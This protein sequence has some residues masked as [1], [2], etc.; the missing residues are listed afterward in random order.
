MPSNK[1]IEN[2]E[3]VLERDNIPKTAFFPYRKPVLQALC[4]KHRLFVPCTGLSRNIPVKGD[5][6]TALLEY[7]RSRKTQAAGNEPTNLQ[8]ELETTRGN[9]SDLH[10]ARAQSPGRMDVDIENDTETT[11]DARDHDELRPL[12]QSKNQIVVPPKQRSIIIKLYG[13]AKDW[14]PVK[15]VEY[16]CGSDGHLDL[17][18]VRQELGQDRKILVSMSFRPVFEYTPGYILSHDIQDLMDGG[19]LRATVSKRL[20]GY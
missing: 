7:T 1:T 6:I 14:W 5:Y 8:Y 19:F 3:L 13:D 15:Q 16:L 2:A 11:A 20:G 4:E 12:A 10:A 17:D 9:N 18:G